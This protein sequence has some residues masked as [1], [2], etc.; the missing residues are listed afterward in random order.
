MQYQNFFIRP[1]QP[2]DYDA[3]VQLI[4]TILAEYGLR[5]EPDGADADVYQVEAFYHQTGGEFW[6]VESQGK[7]VGTAAYYPTHRGNHAVEIRKMYL[8]PEARGKGLGQ[9]L[10]QKLEQAIAAKGFQ[11]IWL[12]TVSVLKEAVKLYERQ[13]YHLMAGV[14]TKRCDLVYMKR[15]RS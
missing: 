8:R 1:W 13:G 11:E 4:A 14:E 2:D 10:L 7:L 9:F 12:E 6:V 3:S 15:L 5:C